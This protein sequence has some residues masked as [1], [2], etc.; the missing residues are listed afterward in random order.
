MAEPDEAELA[1]IEPV[2]E[3]V[4]RAHRIV[5]GHVVV[6]QRREQRALPP[7]NPFHKPCHRSP[8]TA[9]SCKS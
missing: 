1:E 8:P 4:D 6:K 3:N 7:I 2:D 9:N 5:L